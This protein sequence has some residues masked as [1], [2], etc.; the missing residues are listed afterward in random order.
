MREEKVVLTDFKSQNMRR[1]CAENLEKLWYSSQD[2]KP[3]L[4]EMQ[5]VAQVTVS[6]HRSSMKMSLYIDG[7][8]V[9]YHLPVSYKENYKCIH[10]KK[11]KGTNNKLSYSHTQ[12]CMSFKH[13]PQLS[14][15]IQGSRRVFVQHMMHAGLKLYFTE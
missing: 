1:E 12:Y 9:S 7:E 4:R 14:S 6:L 8:C 2:S 11:K 5:I 15:E 3:G 10:T 13:H